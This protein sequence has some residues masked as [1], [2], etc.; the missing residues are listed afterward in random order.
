MSNLSELL[1]TGGGQNAVDFVATGTLASG[2]TVALKSDGTV[3]AVVETSV[4]QSVG[5]PTTYMFN[6]AL[7]NQACYDTVNNKVIVSFVSAGSPSAVVGTVSGTSISFGS[8]VNLPGGSGEY[9]VCAFDT[10][11]N[12]VVFSFTAAVNSNYGTSVVGTVSGTSI[13]F[14]S[15]VVFNSGSTYYCKTTFDSTNNKVVVIYQDVSNADR[16]TAIVGT[17]SGTSISFGSEVVFNT[18]TQGQ[19]QDIVFDPASE[20]VVLLYGNVSNGQYGTACIGTVSGTSI[21]F[22]TAV[23]FASNATYGI[24]ADYDSTSDKIIIAIR[25]NPG[26]I[27]GSAFFGT[28][29]GTSISFSAKST[30]D[31]ANVDYLSLTYDPF[32]DKFVIF[33]RDPSSPYQGRARPGTVS[34]SSLTL[35]NEVTFESG[36]TAYIGSVFDPDTNQIVVA[37]KDEGNSNYGK[38]LMFRNASTSSNNTSFIGI[39]AEAISNAA[40]GAVNVYGGIN[41]AQSGLTI[42]SDYYVQTDGTLTTAS[43]SPA[44]K[45]GQAI[46]ATT[47]NMMD[48]T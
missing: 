23:I 37:F 3:V 8:V 27:T 17:V 22:G 42:A 46:S 36:G 38:A 25:H 45:V 2:Q 48:L 44:V 16:G 26:T 5:S 11:S 31:A 18:G 24:S 7:E 9:L 1:P 35:E 19:G 30:F 39:T 28:V 32:S 29:S 13:S 33:W 34:V 10:N 41:E 6:S 14:G 15:T 21:S 43:A 20:K 47:I 4:S 12:K 40:T